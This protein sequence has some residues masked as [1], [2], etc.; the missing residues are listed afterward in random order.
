M[1]R[2]THN[3]ADGGKVVADHTDDDTNTYGRAL[4]DRM[5]RM[6]GMKDSIPTPK[7][8]T[9]ETSVLGTGTASKAADL[10]TNKRKKQ[11]EELGL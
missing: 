1:V 10:I 3:Y 2:R 11:M 5:R 7:K 4:Y 9:T 6:V 8:K